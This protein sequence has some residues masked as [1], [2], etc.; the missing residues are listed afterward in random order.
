MAKQSYYTITEAIERLQ[1]K[2][3]SRLGVNAKFFTTERCRPALVDAAQ[4]WMPI[5]PAQFHTDET[6]YDQSTAHGASEYYVIPS[7]IYFF[8]TCEITQGGVVYK[9]DI[10]WDPAVFRAR[11][12]EIARYTD[13]EQFVVCPRGNRLYLA[14]VPTTTNV[15]RWMGRKSIRDPADVPGGYLWVPRGPAFNFVCNAALVEAMQGEMRTSDAAQA[16]V[17]LFEGMKMVF[18]IEDRTKTL[19]ARGQLSD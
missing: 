6:M 5:L 19:K 9:T 10:E 1:A 3:G 17:N 14:P 4:E 11:K 13:L 16:L 15:I 2:A 18:G 7:E 12:R 8:E